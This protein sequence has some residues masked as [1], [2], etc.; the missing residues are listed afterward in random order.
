M[1]RPLVHRVS[2]S[3]LAVLLGGMIACGS[4]AQTPSQIPIWDITQSQLNDLLIPVDYGALVNRSLEGDREA[5]I[6]LIRLGQYTDAAGALGFGVLLQAIA[7]RIG[8]EAFA[9]ACRGLSSQ[10]RERTYHILEAGFDYGDEAYQVEDL[11]RQLP[12]TVEVL[13]P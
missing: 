4:V 5:L 12:L 8:D 13:K 10:E 3:V 2:L 1:P 7:L 9:E 6:S 11:P